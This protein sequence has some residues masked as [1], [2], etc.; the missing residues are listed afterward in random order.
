MIRG[1]GVATTERVS[2]VLRW[3]IGAP[4]AL[5]SGLGTVAVPAFQIQHGWDRDTSLMGVVYA[6]VFVGSILFLTRREAGRRVLGGASTAF[7]MFLAFIVL[8]QPPLL[9]PY[10]FQCTLG[11]AACIVIGAILSLPSVRATM[12]EAQGVQ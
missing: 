10:R 4:L 8:T 9:L 3:L 11:I 2:A 1:E 7:A 5:V 6:W 12:R